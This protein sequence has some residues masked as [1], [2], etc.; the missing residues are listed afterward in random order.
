MSS[1]KLKKQVKIDIGFAMDANIEPIAPRN[2]IGLILQNNRRFRHLMDAR[3]LTP[4]GKYYFQK[5]NKVVPK[6]FY[7]QDAFRKGRIMLIMTLDGSARAVDG[8]P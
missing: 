7:H 8:A 5:T 6:H 3:G 4:A 1:G 2:G